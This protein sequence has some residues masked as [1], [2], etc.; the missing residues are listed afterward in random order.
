MYN[1]KIVR[2]IKKEIVDKYSNEFLLSKLTN[3][4]KYVYDNPNYNFYLIKFNKEYSKYYRQLIMAA[5][6]YFIRY[7]RKDLS[8]I[9][10]VDLHVDSMQ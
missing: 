8:F 2:T 3:D 1:E 5:I 9:K 10:T 6:N 4:D 7:N